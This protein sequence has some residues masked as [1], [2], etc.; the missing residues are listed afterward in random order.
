[1]VH[2]LIVILDDLKVLPDLL[3]AW[4]EARVPGATILESVGAY[5][6]HTWLERVGLGALERLFEAEEIRRRTLLTA[7]DDEA[8]LERAVAEAERVVGSFER[9]NSGIL[10]VLPVAEA[11]GLRKERLPIPE[12]APPHP[13]CAAWREM[14][15]GEIARAAGLEPVA[16]PPDAPLDEVARALAARPGVRVACVV[17]EDGRLIGLLDIHTIAEDLL[18][19]IL[20]EELFREI[21]DL[22]RVAKFTQKTRIRTA[23]DGMQRPVWVKETD[24][25]KQAL[26]LMHEHRLSGLPVVDESYH[27]VGYVDL[28]GLLTHCLAQR[29]AEKEKAR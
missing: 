11:R 15:V 25:L 21:T 28:L 6:A 12:T 16:V 17:S 1:M 18:F 26:M 23:A 2:L 29:D 24:T 22:E 20:P 7:I 4:R 13:V 9:P 5:R 14:R 10:L 19:Y 27:V 8:L 3:H